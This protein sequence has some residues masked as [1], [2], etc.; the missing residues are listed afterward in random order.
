M[1]LKRSAR[2]YDQN[3]RDIA[4]DENGGILYIFEDNLDRKDYQKIGSIAISDDSDYALRFNKHDLFISPY[5]SFGQIRGCK[6][7]FPITTKKGC[8][9]ADY[10]TDN[11]FDA[12]K[13]IIDA[14]IQEIKKAV[15]KR[16]IKKI[17]FP[18]QGLIN[19]RYSFIN[20]DRAPKL[21]RYIIKKEIELSKL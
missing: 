11:D 14:D 9:F 20:M 12:F 6:M 21:F 2:K 4:D 19:T 8:D 15:K 1:E 10:W 7:A 3:Y 17:I 5:S 13:K 18:N 16:G